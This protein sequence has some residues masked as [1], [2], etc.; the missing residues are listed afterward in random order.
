MR[1]ALAGKGG[2]G[3]T[4]LAATMARLLARAGSRVVAID[5]DSNPNLAVALGVDRERRVAS[6]PAALVSRRLDG[7]RL[8]EPIDTVLDRYATLAPDGVQV[9][10]MG[11]PGHADEGCLCSAHATVS[12]VLS[13]LGEQSPVNTVVDLE[14]SP[15]HLSRGTARHADLLMLVAEPYYRA[16][17]AVRRL[18]DLAAELP[19]PTIVVV[20]NKVRDP[21]DAGAIAEFCDRHDLRLA[22][23]V[24]WSQDVADADR[25]GVAVI[26]HAPASATVSGVAEMLEALAA[27]S[28]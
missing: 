22:G 12:A 7:P 5:A 14:A 23:T 27:L 18:A 20:G 9:L 17:E 19:I 16:L 21:Q 11:A 6:L 26:D 8:N 15:E 4:T 2:A 1:V 28:R 3:K 25:R 10:E 13:D 24:P